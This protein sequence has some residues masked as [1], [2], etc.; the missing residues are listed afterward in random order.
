MGIRGVKQK[1][2]NIPPSCKRIIKAYEELGYN[3]NPQP[4]VPGA[5][6]MTRGAE[7]IYIK[8]DKPF[9]GVSFMNRE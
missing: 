5:L 6:A 9:S 8:T 2:I 3:I 4:R 1:P 7:T